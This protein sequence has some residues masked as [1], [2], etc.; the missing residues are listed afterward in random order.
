M[1][2]FFREGGFGMYP[3]ALLRPAAVMPNASSTAATWAAVVASSQ[4]TDT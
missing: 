4:A 1:A 2:D 3:T